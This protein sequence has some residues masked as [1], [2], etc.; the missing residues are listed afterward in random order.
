[1]SITNID[2]IIIYLAII[3][4]VLTAYAFYLNIVIMRQ[5]RD[6]RLLILKRYDGVSVIARGKE[7]KVKN[8]KQYI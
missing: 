7:R 4:I 2:I 3:I 5:S 1:M 6:I 8:G